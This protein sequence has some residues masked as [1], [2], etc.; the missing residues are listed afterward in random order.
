MIQNIAFY[1]GNI[2]VPTFGG[3]D[4]VTLVLAK[5]LKEKGFKVFCIYSGGVKIS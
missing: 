2:P 1:W 5:A 4:R 3:I